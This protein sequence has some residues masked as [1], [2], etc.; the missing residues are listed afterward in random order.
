MKRNCA[1]KPSQESFACINFNTVFA[2]RYHPIVYKYRHLRKHPGTE[3]RLY[4]SNFM[5]G[6]YISEISLYKNILIQP[7]F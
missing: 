2:S 3:E 7:Y 5:T 1:D 6:N 4:Q